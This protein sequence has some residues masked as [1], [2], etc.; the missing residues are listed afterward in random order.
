MV[1]S[2]VPENIQTLFSVPNGSRRDKVTGTIL[3]REGV[4]SGVSDLILLLHKHKH[5]F[6]SLCI[7]IRQ[8]RINKVKTKKNGNHWRNQ[9]IT[10]MSFV[11][12]LI[13]IHFSLAICTLSWTY[14][15]SFNKSFLCIIN[16]HVEIY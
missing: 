16:S 1:P 6:A 5:G 9:H 15:L 13:L 3:I 2:P 11:R 14:D 8:V 7:E 12:T 10:S 4:V